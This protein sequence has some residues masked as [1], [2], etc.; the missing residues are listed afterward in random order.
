[1]KS[2]KAIVAVTLLAAAL[3]ACDKNPVEQNGAPQ[4][5]L[6]P[7]SVVMGVFES[8]PLIATVRD[9]SGA[10]QYVALEYVSRDQSMATVNATLERDFVIRG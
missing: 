10:I 5:T 9:A 1:M 4:L 7:G 6:S 2:V 3:L 8:S